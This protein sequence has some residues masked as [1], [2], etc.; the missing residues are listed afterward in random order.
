[1]QRNGKFNLLLQ[2]MIVLGI[3]LVVNLISGSVFTR[4]DLTDDGR[5]TLS[6]VSAE[7]LDTLDDRAF[8]SR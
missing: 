8:V 7:Y 4:F 2:L 6:E 5:D 3:V 1:M